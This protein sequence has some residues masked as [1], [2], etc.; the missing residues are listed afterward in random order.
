MI[1]VMGATGHTGSEIAKLLLEAGENVRALG[2]SHAKLAGLERAGAQPF[3]GDATD[4]DFLTE[5]FRGADAV[6]TLLPYDPYAPGYHSSQDRLGE[7]IASAVRGAGVPYV[8]ALSSVGADEPS[9]TGFVASLH[10]QEQRL[11]TLEDANVLI[12]RPGSFFE[13]FYAALE[14]IEHE[15]INGDSVSPDLRMPMIATRDIAGVAAHALVARDWEGV[16]VRELLGER[17]LSYAEATMIIGAEI[18]KPDLEYVQF[19]YADMAG[20]LTKKGF[21]EDFA[22]LHVELTRALNEGRVTAREARKPENTTPT[23]FEDYAAELSQ[24]LGV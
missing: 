15:G 18:G 13:N 3:A 11:R 20:S 7:A 8:V 2:R 10:A 6:Y 21:A 12:L 23:R 17:D 24:A 19:P 16:V 9:G 1:T 14:L 5:A 22:G 4:R